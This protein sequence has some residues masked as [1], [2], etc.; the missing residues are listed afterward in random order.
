LVN[1][2]INPIFYVEDVV[3]DLIMF[4]KKLVLS[5]DILQLKLE[6]VLL[7]S[8][9]LD[10]WS[11]KGKRRKTTGTGRMSHLKTLPRKFKNGF[12]SG[13]TAPAR[14]VAKSE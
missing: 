4:R 7:Y 2:I 14:K 8:L 11:E 12:R 3:I 9:N 10:E 6:D 13:Q 1:V 5:V